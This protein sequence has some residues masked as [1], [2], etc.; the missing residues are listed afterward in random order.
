MHEYSKKINK[1][2]K[3]INKDSK[4]MNKDSKKTKKNYKGGSNNIKTKFSS[5]IIK[6]VDPKELI[7]NEEFPKFSYIGGSG[8]HGVHFTLLKNQEIRGDGGAMNYMSGNIEMNTTSGGIM[9]GLFRSLSGSSIFY[10]IFRNPSQY[11]GFINLSGFYPGNVGCFYIPSGKTFCLV[12]DTYICSTL[13]LEISTKLRF[14]GFI[15]GYG[16][17]FVK[18]TSTNTP[19]LLFISSFGNII[20]ITI[21]PG[22]SVS[23]DNGVLIG[24]DENQSINTRSVGGFKSLL[25]SGEGLISNI[26]NSGNTPITIY[27]QS[28]SKTAYI[29]YMKNMIGTNR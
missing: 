20:P 4:K 10:N 25:F 18:V 7:N 22:S 17:A 12:Y 23:I 2:S 16:L 21:N 9:S 1:D 28:R 14:G 11:D 19:G 8:F 5:D 15:L 24:F 26:S 29:D 13:N 3:K 6:L 27:V